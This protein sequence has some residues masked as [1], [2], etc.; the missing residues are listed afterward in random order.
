MV[1]PAWIMT[2]AAIGVL[3]S[4][5]PSVLAVAR[6]SSA[7]SFLRTQTTHTVVTRLGTKQ[8][9]NTERSVQ[10]TTSP[11]PPPSKQPTTNSS[12]GNNLRTSQR[13]TTIPAEHRTRA[14]VRRR[15]TWWTNNQPVLLAHGYSAHRTHRT[16]PSFVLRSPRHRPSLPASVCLPACLLPACLPVC[17]RAKCAR[18]CGKQICMAPPG[19]ESERQ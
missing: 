8:K 6:A 12:G 11:S 2:G 1:N 4:T 16:H 19:R 18:V 5:V 14:T 15:G 13:Q 9:Q 10:W 7:H 17:R 3:P